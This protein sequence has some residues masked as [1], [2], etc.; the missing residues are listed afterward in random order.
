MGLF[1]TSY[2][3]GWVTVGLHWLLFLLV[4]GLIASGKYSHSL[5]QGEKAP[6]VIGVHAQIGVAVFLL[7]AFRLLWRLFNARVAPLSA[8]RYIRIAGAVNHWL[9]YVA[10]LM[11]AGGGVLMTQAGG[12]DVHFLGLVLPRLLSADSDSLFADGA[13]L[14]EWHHNGGVVIIALVVIHVGAALVHHFV[15]ADDTL[16]RMWFSYKAPRQD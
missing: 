15:F 6:Q 13:L 3:F 5:P 8:N 2:R 4:V 12:R 10:V 11:Q 16:R 9:I 1:N 14:R 7:M